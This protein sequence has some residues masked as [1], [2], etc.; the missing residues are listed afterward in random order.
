LTV[1]RLILSELAPVVMAHHA[2]FYTLDTSGEEQSLVLLAGYAYEQ[3][4]A[5]GNRLAL[6]QGLIGQ[7][8]VEKQKILLTNIPPDYINISSGLG[9][10]RPLNIIVLPVIFEGQVKAV[11][12][13]ASFDRFS[14]THEAFL[15]QLTESIGIVLNTIEANMRTEDLLAQSQSM[16][17]ELTNR[18]EEL[19]TTNAELQSNA[20]LLALQNEE[21][22]RKN[23]EVEQARQALEEKARQLAITSK[24]KSE[25]MANMSH[26]LR[27]PL[28]SLLILSDQLS[29]NP[30]GNLNSKQVEYCKTIHSSGNDLL[31]LI[32]DIL[33]LAKIESGTVV[34][35][36]GELR[37]ADLVSYVE[38]TFRHMA[39]SKELEFTIAVDPALPES[40]LTDSKRL[41]QIIKNLL[42][43]AFKFT[44]RGS[45]SLLI[46]PATSGWGVHN[47][48]LNEA[49][50][51]IAISVSDTGIGIAPDK[52]RVIFEAFQQADGSTSRKY[53][54][55]G[56]GLNI[57]RE[58]ARLLRGEITLKSAAGEGSTFTLYV[59]QTY[60][61]AK[62]PRKALSEPSRAVPTAPAE[63]EPV[64]LEV[65]PLAL[66]NEAG[67]DRNNIQPGDRVLLIVDNDIQFARLVLETA[68]EKGFKGLV[69]PLGSA[70]LVLAREQHP[71]AI[72]LDIR[73][74]DIDGWRVLAYL[75]SELDTRHIPVAVISTVDNPERGLARGAIDVL[76]K[77]I[78][79][80]ALLSS[81]V[82][83]L[84][85]FVC[86]RTK[87]ILV[88]DGDVQSRGAY[89]EMFESDDLE[90]T[91]AEAHGE[92]LDLVRGQR[93]DC[94][95]LGDNA[96]GR[97]GSKGGPGGFASRND[98]G[99]SLLDGILES[100]L[101]PAQSL[102]AL[103]SEHHREALAR[104]RDNPRLVVVHSQDQL[105]DRVAL[106][107][108]RPLSRLTAAQ[109]ARIEELHRTDGRLAGRKVLIVDDDIRNIFALTSVLEREQM[110]VISAETGRDAIDFLQNEPEI[111]LVLM[112]IM[113]PEMDGLCT[114]RAIR[115]LPRFKSLPIIAVT[116]KAMKGDREKCIE[117]G[118][119][120]YL[121]KP[122]DPDQL[123]SVLRAWLCR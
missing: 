31:M 63:P 33:D 75:K 57:S 56:L 55:T 72:T 45:V 71:D 93:W 87:R 95:V 90:L 52:Q 43:N 121:A 50:S 41:Q 106:A 36:P 59:P 11:L 107:L 7:C 34:L 17:K 104:S 20:R 29:K 68:R 37:I 77:P 61:P 13:L 83:R 105:L 100:P 76:A 38:R 58:I 99:Q 92:A 65:E 12:E 10:A 89:R 98:N 80:G 21:V 32:N 3:P 23:R 84:A 64:L 96:I 85:K 26:E 4:N 122:V 81:F 102:I 118:A 27:T 25:F 60:V 28:N 22:E 114:T 54:G 110:H 15:D 78:E 53:G 79:S 49:D 46:T 119:W 66:P 16:A 19:E 115:E 40:L 108:H 86:R 103:A 42:A 6:G 8:A 24:Y 82:D 73:L 94:V 39:E 30:D 14:P 44:H 112:D 117:A 109:R 62:T 51:V 97:N 123:L 5:V 67:D 91:F 35:D 1:G 101:S 47:Q 48:G 69:T 116:A 113:M 111:E 18:Q 2:V 88:V 9:S 120:D 74:P 70:A